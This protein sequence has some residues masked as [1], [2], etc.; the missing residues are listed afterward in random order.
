MA[1]YYWR[2][3]TANARNSDGTFVGVGIFDFNRPRNWLVPVGNGYTGATHAPGR[4]ND[5]CYFGGVVTADSPCLFGGY[6]GSV[7]QTSSGVWFNSAPFP[8]GTSGATTNSAVNQ[9]HAVYFLGSE[10]PR[11]YPFPYFGGGITGEIYNYCTSV[12][13]LST[14]SFF[15]GMQ[16][17]TGSRISKGL[18]LRSR[19]YSIQTTGRIDTNF[20]LG[21]TGASGYPNYNIVDIV[22]ISTY[23]LATNQTNWIDTNVMMEGTLDC[24]EYLSSGPSSVPYTSRYRG[25]GNVTL[26]NGIVKTV[27]TDDWAELFQF[28]CVSPTAGGTA[29]GC[30]NVGAA[31]PLHLTLDG[32]TADHVMLYQVAKLNVKTNCTLGRINTGSSQY[33]GLPRMEEATQ[34]GQVVELLRIAGTINSDLTDAA[35]GRN[36]SG[37]TAPQSRGYIN[38]SGMWTDKYG[39]TAAQPYY[40]Y[41]P[42]VVLGSLGSGMTF[43]AKNAYVNSFIWGTQPGGGIYQNNCSNVIEQI[44]LGREKQWVLE[45]EGNVGLTNCTLYN[46]VMRASPLSSPLNQIQIDN[47]NLC[48]T[49]VL[50][51]GYAPLFDNW[52]FGAISGSGTSANI[53]GGINFVGDGSYIMGDSGVR[54]LNTA[55]VG[56]MNLRTNQPDIAY[57]EFSDVLPQAP[58]QKRIRR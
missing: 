47:A 57:P 21:K 13:G 25:Y 52:Y 42:K 10:N 39:Q 35:L 49:S 56:G 29:A 51:F 46:S 2:G 5:I 55:I 53:I 38:L 17:S 54:L 15:T 48:W 28:S 36:V 22:P 1:T 8:N 43:S 16:G 12:L 7:G 18:V 27:E 58:A 37:L 40:R 4:G 19:N 14:Q 44:G 9:L 23:T 6:S 33:M 41:K 26:R 45:F 34:E 3:A 31:R 11:K 50:D 24:G 20:A 32:I 30:E